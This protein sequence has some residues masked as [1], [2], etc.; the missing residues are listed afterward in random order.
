MMNKWLESLGQLSAT[1]AVK[2]GVL[3]GTFASIGSNDP[4]VE[5]KMAEAVREMIRALP[6]DVIGKASSV[7]EVLTK[8]TSA[9]AK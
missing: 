3:E 2:P 4:M 7:S 9:A 1:E 5:A 6:P 8:V